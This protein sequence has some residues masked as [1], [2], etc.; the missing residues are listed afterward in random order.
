M[1]KDKQNKLPWPTKA[2]MEQIYEKKLWG[3]IEYKFY[4]GEGSHLDEIVQPYLDVVNDLLN[5]FPEPIVVCDLGCGD[6]NVG[7]EIFKFTKNYIGVDIVKS[8]IDH[9]NENFKNNNLSF[10]CL[11]I[12][13]DPLPKGDCALIRQVLQHLS[14]HEVRSILQKLYHYKYIIITEHLPQGEF[15]AN[16]D[17]VSGQGIRIKKNSGLDL[18]VSPFNWKVKKVKELLVINLKEGKGKLVTTLY[19]L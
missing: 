2:A 7:K 15:E 8:L 17:I 13:I 6:F 19:F 10:K 3:G 11:D 9:N 1:Q 18:L 5:S 14:N 16:K 12:A 4:S